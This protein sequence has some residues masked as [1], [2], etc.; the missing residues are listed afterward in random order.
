MGKLSLAAPAAGA[1]FVV[2]S[3]LDTPSSDPATGVC[4]DAQGKCTLRAAIMVANFVKGTVTILLT[5]GL[6]TLARPGYDDAALVGD[7]DIGTDLTIQGAGSGV[8]I[9]DGNGALTG[10][11]VFQVLNSVQTVTFSGMT[12]RSGQS[13]SSTV[14]VIGGG[15]IYMEGAGHLRLSD[16][17]LE[18][19]TALNGGGLYANL[20][21]QGGSVELDHV[22]VRDNT[23][24]EGGVG[25]GGGV[26][27]QFLSNSSTMD[28]HDS[29]VYANTADGTGGGFFTA[30]P[31]LSHWSI[32]RSE[33]NSNTAASG[34]GIGNFLP[35][36]LADSRLRDN[37]A[38]IDGGGIEAFS[39]LAITRT[40]LVAN[41]AGRFGGG[42]FDLATG[43]S[44]LYN[45]F[46]DIEQ[47]TLSGNYAQYGG[48]IY[49]DGFANYNSRLTLTDSTLSGN[50]VSLDGGGLN[51]YNGQAQLFNTTIAGN[52]VRLGFPT[53][54][55]GIGGGL[56]IATPAVITV[57]NTLIANNTRG[58]GIMLPGAD[59]CYSYGTTGE[60][61]FSLIKTLTNCFITGPQIGNI[62]G[63]DP[64]L[65]PLGY[66]GGSTP[67]LALLPGSPAIDAGATAGCSGMAGAPISIDQRGYPRPYGAKCDIGALEYDPNAAMI[68][69]SLLQK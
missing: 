9:V 61:A 62:T 68:Y 39:P 63:L 6:Y 36:S 26:M 43:S 2:N 56:Y 30:G 19:N 16:V 59:D 51:L 65:G 64:H 3:S 58:N 15:G 45:D 66:Y 50:T 60:L 49:H 22:I 20:S 47:S 4:A 53:P 38:A 35:L 33:I 23:V 54:G 31:D 27:A 12:I 13:L 34:A 1:T 28:V 57:T 17:I 69:L 24:T 44:A 25:A 67:T 29:L 7:L 41:S 40:T 21:A 10:D 18:G 14:G 48:G 32:E 8:T 55:P 5:A 46:A 11:R 52:Q 42:I 37:H